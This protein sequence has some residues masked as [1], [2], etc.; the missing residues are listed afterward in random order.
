MRSRG[1]HTRGRGSVAAR[2][3]GADTGCR[4]AACCTERRARG[5]HCRRGRHEG[6][7]LGHAAGPRPGSQ[8]HEADGA[9]GSRLALARATS[10]DGGQEAALSRRA[11]TQGPACPT[12]TAGMGEPPC[13]ACPRGECRPR[14]GGGLSDEPSEAPRVRPEGTALCTGAEGRRRSPEKTRDGSTRLPDVG[15]TTRPEDLQGHSG[16]KRGRP[17]LHGCGGGWRRP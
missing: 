1:Q 11:E 9:P 17:P 14:R 16:R 3:G 6:G 4:R 12:A 2:P 13:H 10:P 15:V 8:R 5:E 7:T